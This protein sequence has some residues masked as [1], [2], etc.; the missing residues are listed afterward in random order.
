MYIYMYVCMADVVIR[1]MMLMH[2]NSSAL[3]DCA[4]GT[5]IT[6][7]LSS[8]PNPDC[9]DSD[10]GTMVDLYSSTGRIRPATA[11]NGVPAITLDPSAALP[12][13][14]VP[15]A[16]DVAPASPLLVAAGLVVVAVPLAPVAA[17]VYVPSIVSPRPPS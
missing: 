10:S 14:E 12:A 3:C 6:S 9:D 2:G 4:A 16:T 13:H 1:L 7:R 5:L 15:P 8:P 17:S 11:T